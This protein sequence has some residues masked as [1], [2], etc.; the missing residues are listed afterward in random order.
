MNLLCIRPNKGCIDPKYLLYY[1]KSPSYSLQLKPLIKRAIN[2]ASISATN[3]KQ[4]FVPLPPLSEQRRIVELLDQADALRK[5]R[6]EADAKAERILPA[7][8]IKM[9]GDPTEWDDSRQTQPLGELVDLQGGGTPS[10]KHQSIG[11]GKFLGFLLR[12]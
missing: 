8:F 4:T 6:A 11:R 3:L 1:L 5:K 12:I 2:Q 10:K 9:F 7:L